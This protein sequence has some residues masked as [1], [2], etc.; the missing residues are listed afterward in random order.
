MT[1]GFPD[2]QKPL[3]REKLVMIDLIVDPERDM[4]PG[5]GAG[6]GIHIEISCRTAAPA[7]GSKKEEQGKAAAGSSEPHA[8]L[9]QDE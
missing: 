9:A 1:P 4:A 3:I 8:S 2:Q 7:V 6:I 5:G